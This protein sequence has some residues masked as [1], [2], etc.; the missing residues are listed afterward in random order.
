[1]G[2]LDV[3]CGEARVGELTLSYFLGKGSSL[4][5]TE[6]NLAAPQCAVWSIVRRRPS[7]AGAALPHRPSPSR[8][9]N[10][11]SIDLRTALA[12]LNMI[13]AFCRQNRTVE[14]R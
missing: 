13:V 10:S 1:M 7:R 8:P 4:I 6:I 3:Q 12:I 11:H 2:V 14:N 5:C 9:V